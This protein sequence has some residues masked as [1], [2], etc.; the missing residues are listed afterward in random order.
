MEVLGIDEVEDAP[1]LRASYIQRMRELHPDVNAEDTTAQATAVN[2]A[3]EFLVSVRRLRSSVTLQPPASPPARCHYSRA[4]MQELDSNSK[5]LRRR[6]T[7]PFG[8]CTSSPD[9]LFVNPFACGVDPFMWRE[10][11]ATAREQPDSPEDALLRRR[12]GVSPGTLH[13]LTAEQLVAAEALLVE[14]EKSLAFE[15]TAWLLGDAMLRASR[16]NGFRSR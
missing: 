4:A 10:L 16:S 6:A 14:M 8:R 2:V 13:F 9:Q 1:Q 5:T 15:V 12:V 7:D 3:Y 11:Q